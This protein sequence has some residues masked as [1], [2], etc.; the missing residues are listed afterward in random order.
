MPTCS[1]GYISKRVAKLMEVLGTR[2]VIAIAS[3]LKEN[4]HGSSDGMSNEEMEKAAEVIE[5]YLEH[6]VENTR[7]LAKKEK[8]STRSKLSWPILF[9]K[10]QKK[11]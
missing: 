6:W 1:E 9:L 11:L 10:Q 2:S 4:I 7:G 3:T 5:F 8:D